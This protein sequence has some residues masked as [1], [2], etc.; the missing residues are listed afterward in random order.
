M[1]APSKATA[2]FLHRP[3]CTFSIDCM[4]LLITSWES[5][6]MPPL[7]RMNPSISFIS[8]KTPAMLKMIALALLLVF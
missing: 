2:Y 5:V 1:N 6:I 7:L 8:H 4:T 3:L